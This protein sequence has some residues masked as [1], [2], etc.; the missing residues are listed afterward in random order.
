MEKAG[1]SSG[2]GNMR[3][4]RSSSFLVFALLIVMAFLAYNYWSLSVKNGDLSNELET[5]QLDF[6]TASDKHL[7]A[8]KQAGDLVKQLDEQK[9]KVVQM[10]AKVGETQQKLTESSNKVNSLNDELKKAQ[11][12]TEAAKKDAENVKQEKSSVAGELET[13]KK[14]LTD[15]QNT[16]K[17][18]DK[19]ACKGPLREVIAAVAKTIGKS[20]ISGALK[21][22]NVDVSSV[23]GDLLAG[24]DAPKVVA[25]Q[26]A[27]KK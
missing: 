17:V 10:E 6:R 13:V 16:P 8:E 11:E 23:A 4:S 12:E 14:Q 2:R 19:E 15:L 22:S 24:D 5:L 26:E 3:S 9:A 18:C 20:P 7:A 25:G 21:Q 1:S 27:G